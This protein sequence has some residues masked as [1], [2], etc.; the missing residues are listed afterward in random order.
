MDQMIEKLH[1]IIENE[2]YR[3]EKDT[4]NEVWELTLTRWKMLHIPLH[5]IEFLLNPKWFH[6]KMSTNAEVI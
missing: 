2:N 5:S 6:K 3:I 1:D 4:R